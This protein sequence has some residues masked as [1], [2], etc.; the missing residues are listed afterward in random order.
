MGAEWGAGNS[1]GW[2][3]ERTAHLTSVETNR[4]Y[5]SVVRDNLARRGLRNVDLQCVDFA[6]LPDEDACHASELLVRARAIPDASLDYALIDSAPRSCLC[7]TVVSKLKAG[8]VLVLDNANWYIPPPAWLRP[9]PSASVS[10]ALG[11]PG[12]AI[13]GNRCMPAFLAQTASWRR[14]WTSDGV[15]AT[16]LFFKP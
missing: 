15:T 3:A 8:A 9:V 2:F 4:A 5:H 1:T 6:W 16:L 11:C 7:E 10:A 14:I 12:S 13:P